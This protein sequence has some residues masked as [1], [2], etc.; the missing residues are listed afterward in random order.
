M[1]QPGEQSIA[2]RGRPSS[3]PSAL[4][5]PATYSKH[6][7]WVLT[8]GDA[9]LWS[10]AAVSAKDFS[11]GRAGRPTLREGFTLIEL[12]L[13]IAILATIA[14][15]LIPNFMSAL[16]SAKIARATADIQALE[17]EI[18][19]YQILNGTLPNTLDDLGRGTFLDPWGTPYQYL[20]FAN[21]SGQ[22]Q[23][24][25][26]RFLVPLNSTYDLY[27]MGADRQSL[28]PITA[29]VSQDDIIRANDG[30]YVGLA[31]KY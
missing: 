22:G 7:A 24:R 30:A 28:P 9:G 21:V 14:A 15:I 10:R 11:S 20:N 17:T 13:V 1:G 2:P 23:M 6:D 8:G 4:L 19:S 29:S 31:S 25:K 18:D 16:D 26:D 27:S 12:V 3:K 5:E